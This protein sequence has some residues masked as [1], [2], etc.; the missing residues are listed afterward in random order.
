MISNHIRKSA[1]VFIGLLSAS[2]ILVSCGSG[3]T[4][5]TVAST[6]G[7]T[8][9]VATASVVDTAAAFEKA[10]SKDGSWIIATLKDLT[11]DK[12]L[13]LDG[14][15]TNGRKDD[16]GKDIYQRKIGLY[17]QDA[18]RKVLDRF[19]LTAPKLTINSRNASLEHGTFVG[20]IYVAV[21][22]FKLVTARVEGNVYFKTEEIKNSFTIDADSVITGVQEVRSF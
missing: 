17:T 15:F 18:D 13:V 21:P 4:T 7:T 19:K 8:D 2:L 5:T 11:I 20:D 14:D 16:A 22:N 3:T 1:L 9:A 10:I 6:T 12:D